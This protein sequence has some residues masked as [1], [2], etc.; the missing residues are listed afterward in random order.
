MQE[1]QVVADQASRNVLALVEL[2]QS[3]VA[4]NGVHAVSEADLRKLGAVLREKVSHFVLSEDGW[5]ES[6]RPRRKKPVAQPEDPAPAEHE[7]GGIDLF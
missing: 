5:D 6:M 4:E 2:N 1:Q 3:V 7:S